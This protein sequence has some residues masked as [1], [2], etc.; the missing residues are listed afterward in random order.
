ML[1]RPRKAIHVLGWRVPLTPGLFVARRE[2]FARQLAQ[3]FVVR[4]VNKK[5][6]AAALA[7]ASRGGIL[8]EVAKSVSPLSRAVMFG[9]L[10]K[11]STEDIGE[12]CEAVAESVKGSGMVEHLAVEKVSAMSAAEIETMLMDVV[13]KE[14]GA[15]TVLGGVLGLVIGSCQSILQLL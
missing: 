14:F 4:F 12:L 13:E 8:D 2:A 7:Q 1:F 5:D 3:A 9:T 10:D 11:M 15:I 6:L